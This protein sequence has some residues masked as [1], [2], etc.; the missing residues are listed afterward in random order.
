MKKQLAKYA[1]L[2]QDLLGDGA[3]ESKLNALEKLSLDINGGAEHA[4][5]SD[6]AKSVVSNRSQY[7][8]FSFREATGG[9]SLELSKEKTS[10]PLLGG[11][12]IKEG[13]TYNPFTLT[14]NLAGLSYDVPQQYYGYIMLFGDMGAKIIFAPYSYDSST[15]LIDSVEFVMKRVFTI[16]EITATVIQPSQAP[17]RFTN[18]TVEPVI[19]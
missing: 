11:F 8:S 15:P 4:T 7:F 3:K 14:A 10:I 17:P 2:K 19:Y 6:L 13:E 12:F 9:G 1:Q 5:N 18:I 16:I